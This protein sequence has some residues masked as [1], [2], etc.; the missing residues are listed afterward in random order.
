LYKNKV[1]ISDE[2]CTLFSEK[3]DAFYSSQ[4]PDDKIKLILLGFSFNSATT[5]FMRIKHWEKLFT[6]AKQQQQSYNKKL[7]PQLLISSMTTPELLSLFLSHFPNYD[8]STIDPKTHHN[9]LDRIIAMK[10]YFYLAPSDV[11][12]AIHPF[13]R[14]TT[15]ITRRNI[16]GSKLGSYPN[17]ITKYRT[18]RILNLFRSVIL[19]GVQV[20]FKCSIIPSNSHC[21]FSFQNRFLVVMHIKP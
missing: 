4:L 12:Q 7:A 3:L 6:E 17:E 14:H 8:L 13:T 10:P 15:M 2:I 1:I 20:C 11:S 9:I 5:Q 16:D 21:L 18:A 19:Q